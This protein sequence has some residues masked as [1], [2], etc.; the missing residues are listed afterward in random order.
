MKYLDLLRSARTGEDEEGVSTI[1]GAG[2]HERNERNEESRPPAA[3]AE[4]EQWI[5]DP[6]PDLEGDSPLWSRL[7][8]LAYDRDGEDTNGLFGVLHGF[9]CLGAGLV[10]VD[11]RARLV[12]GELGDDYPTEREQ[13]LV[14][15]AF[16]L[17]KLLA[18]LAAQTPP[19]AG[20][21]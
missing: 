14:P 4:R 15:H 8:T 16:A 20:T 11:G 18:D 19:I 9:R 6:R 5:V 1:Q 7:L 12:A 13:W 2:P 21:G 3:T 10:V 17:T